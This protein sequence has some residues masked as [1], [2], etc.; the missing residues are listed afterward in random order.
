MECTYCIINNK[1]KLL[2]NNFDYLKIRYENREN[3]ND[4]YYIDK[5]SQEFN[6]NINE[7]INFNKL[8]LMPF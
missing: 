3:F 5:E 7:D 6:I 4:E 8:V 1:Y 2:I